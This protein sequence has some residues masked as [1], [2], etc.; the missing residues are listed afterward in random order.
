[1]APVVRDRHITVQ[2]QAHLVKDVTQVAA[3]AKL[4]DY[5]IVDARSAPRFRGEEAEP[6]PGVRQGHIP[7]SVNLPFRSLLNPDSTMK[8]VPELQ[9]A[10]AAAGADLTKPVITT[11]GSGVTAA[12]LNLALQRMGKHDHALY[13]GSWAEW[14]M[15]NDLKVVK[16]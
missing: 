4:G 10:F 15:Y 11:C 12:I 5:T 14:G 2:R 6:R 3:A 9:Q 7:A 8:S 13:D 1:M 16:G